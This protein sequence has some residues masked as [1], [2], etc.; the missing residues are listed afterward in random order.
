MSFPEDDAPEGLGSTP[1]DVASA[2]R[3]CQAVFLIGLVIV[4]LFAIFIIAQLL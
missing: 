2:A 4:L 3:G 1:E